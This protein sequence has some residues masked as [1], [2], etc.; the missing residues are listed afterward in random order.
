MII[1]G[2]Q[3]LPMDVLNVNAASAIESYLKI[4]QA[5]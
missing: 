5:N 1:Q 3:R 4:I 2:S